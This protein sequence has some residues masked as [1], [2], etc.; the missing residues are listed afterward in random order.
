MAKSGVAWAGVA[1]W[2]TPPHHHLLNLFLRRPC[3]IGRVCLLTVFEL[4]L[5]VAFGI[6]AG[7]MALAPA[8]SAVTGNNG[9]SQSMKDTGRDLTKRGLKVGVV[10]ADKVSAATKSVVNNVAEMGE[11]FNDLVA[12]ARAELTDDQSARA[13]ADDT[14]TDVIV[15]S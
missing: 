2:R 14:I 15:E 11:S 3:H 5:L 12:E 7:L 8:V 6:G 9:L 4:E 10:V 13:K 1:L